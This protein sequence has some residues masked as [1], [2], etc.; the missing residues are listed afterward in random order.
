MHSI[1]AAQTV[2]A[3]E[4]ALAVLRGALSFSRRGTSLYSHTAGGLS[5]TV[6]GL[7]RACISLIAEL[8]AR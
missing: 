4:S 1:I 6:D 2:E 8:E 5:T 7:Q 3:A